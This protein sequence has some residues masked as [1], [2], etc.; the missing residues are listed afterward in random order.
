M[1]NSF[2]DTL[3]ASFQKH[4]QE[5]ERKIQLAQRKVDENQAK[6]TI[7]IRSNQYEPMRAAGRNLAAAK[8]RLGNLQSDYRTLCGDRVGRSSCSILHRT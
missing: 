8:T 2:N 1:S 5:L 7:A 4:R 6:M 3:R